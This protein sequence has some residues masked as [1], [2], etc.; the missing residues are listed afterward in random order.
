VG[1]KF[2]NNWSLFPGPSDGS[3]TFL[4]NREDLLAQFFFY[5]QEGHL[6]SLDLF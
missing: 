4:I 1:G 5:A 3:S 2:H 6:Y